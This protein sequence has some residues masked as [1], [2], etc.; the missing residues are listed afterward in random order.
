MQLPFLTK[1]QEKKEFFLSLLIH[2]HTV[3]AILFEEVANNIS[4]VA[5]KR[6]AQKKVVDDL[7][8]EELIEASDKLVSSLE[9]SLPE[10]DMVSKTVFSVPY[11]WVEDG[12]IKRDYLL[13]LKKVCDAL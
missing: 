5:T 7:S 1:K 8:S 9:T 6:E 10:H 13:N 12:K 11:S 3:G 2:P 4:I